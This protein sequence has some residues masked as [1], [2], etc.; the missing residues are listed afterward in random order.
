MQIAVRPLVPAVV[1][2]VGPTAIVFV[3]RAQA[4]ALR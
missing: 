1:Q 4:R 3:E 2:R